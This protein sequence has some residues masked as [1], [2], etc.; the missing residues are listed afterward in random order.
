MHVS[1]L[2]ERVRIAPDLPGERGAVMS[3]AGRTGGGPLKRSGSVAVS[4]TFRQCPATSA[5][6]RRLP[7]PRPCEAT[8]LDNSAACCRQ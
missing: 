4:L 8:G 6:P 2:A 7:G 3:P 1:A 5:R